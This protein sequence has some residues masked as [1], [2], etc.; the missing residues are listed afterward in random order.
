M[1]RQAAQLPDWIFSASTK[2]RVIAH[3]LEPGNEGKLL[4]ERNVAKTLG[5]DPRGSIDEHLCALAQLGLLERKDGPR[6]FRVRPQADLEPPV[7]DLRT[8]LLDLLAAL[9]RIPRTAV[10][11]PP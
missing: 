9:D 4:S 11:R 7:R 2:R 5:V 1:A 8:A 10:E 6:R 3:V